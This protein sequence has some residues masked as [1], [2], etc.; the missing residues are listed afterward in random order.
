MS[1]QAAGRAAPSAVVHTIAPVWN[2]ESRVLLLGT[3]PSPRSRTA[4]FYYGNPQNRFWPVLAALFGVA[5]PE[6]A[7]GRREFALSRGIALWDVLASCRIV[8]AS[9][10]TIRDPVPNDIAPLLSAAPIGRV[11]AVGKTAGALY[12]RFLLPRSGIPQQTLPSPSP[13][14]RGRYPL[15]RLVESWRPVAE[16]LR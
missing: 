9:D 7:E 12:D 1:V 15:D 11:F 3:M 14:N 6:T 16:A 13:A 10:A 4:G 2:A 8:G 5:V